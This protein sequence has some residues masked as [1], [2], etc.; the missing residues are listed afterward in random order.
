MDT[1]NSPGTETARQLYAH[2]VGLGLKEAEEAIEDARKIVWVAA[3]SGHPREA[4]SVLYARSRPADALSVDLHSRSLLEVE[5]ILQE[6]RFALYINSY[7]HQGETQ[8]GAMMAA[9]MGTQKAT[10]Q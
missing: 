9:A 1:S 8:F 7:G 6:L 3:F 4:V 5:D 10:M 2:L